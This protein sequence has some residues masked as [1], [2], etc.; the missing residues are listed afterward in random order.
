[1]MGDVIDDVMEDD[2]MVRGNDNCFR[3]VMDC[4]VGR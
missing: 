1:M 2:E 3:G 4:S